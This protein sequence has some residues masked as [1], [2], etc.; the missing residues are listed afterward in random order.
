MG[1]DI[2]EYVEIRKP[3]GTW[4]RVDDK[5]GPNIDYRG[6][7]CWNLD[8]N[9]WLFG[10]LAGVRSVSFTAIKEPRGIPD[11]ASKGVLAAWDDYRGDGH[12]PSYY[13]LKELLDIKKTNIIVTGFVDLENYKEIKK[14]GFPKNWE[15]HLENGSIFG[16]SSSKTA[17]VVSNEEMERLAKL[18]A[19]WDGK[20]YYTECIW[21]YPTNQISEQFFD[22]F[23]PELE[24]LDSN[25][26]NV[27]FVFW[28]DN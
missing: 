11:D 20:Y 6:R 1:C 24:K 28:F 9:Y 2:H 25:P 12:T 21:Q 15:T 23:I 4:E 13:T 19:F 3:D 14:K 18:M 26:E 7:K 16:F 8:R 17:T 5:Y 27:R 10:I 22:V